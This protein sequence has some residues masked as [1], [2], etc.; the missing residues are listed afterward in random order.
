MIDNGALE[1]ACEEAM[2]EESRPKEI[3]DGLLQQHELKSLLGSGSQ[4][5]VW[6]AVDRATGDASAVKLL[7]TSADAQNELKAYRMLS[8]THAHP[9]LL[10]LMYSFSSRCVA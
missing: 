5:E 4:G 10:P 8:R 9:N 1:L 6:R 7:Q 2:D 3:V